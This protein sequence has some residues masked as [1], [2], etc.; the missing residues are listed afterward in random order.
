MSLVAAALNSLKVV[1]INR[2]NKNNRLLSLRNHL[3]TL[4]RGAF[5]VADYC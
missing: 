2:I 4:V 5:R 1:S 3:E